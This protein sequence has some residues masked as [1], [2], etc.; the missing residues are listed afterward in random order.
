MLPEI[1]LFGK[2]IGTYTLLAL[3]GGLIA[4][5]YFIKAVVRR[6]QRDYQAVFFLLWVILGVLVGG[7]LLYAIVN[8][9][10]LPMRLKQEGLLGL[11]GLFGGSVFYGGLIGGLVAGLIS[12]KVMKVDF[13]TY[14]ACMAPIIPLFHAI[15]R[16]GCFLGG[17]CY[18]VVSEFGFVVHGNPY[19][20]FINGISRFPVQLLESGLNLILAAVLFYLLKKSDKNEKLKSSM[21]RIYLISYACI[22]I[23]TEFFRGDIY[24]GFIGPLSTSQFISIIILIVC[25]ASYV[26]PKFVK[27][28]KVSVRRSVFKDT[29]QL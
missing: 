23:F 4:A 17:C 7:H 16:V 10:T 13:L 18:G 5:Y 15:A 27:T 24:R 8:I 20:P 9:G 2:P 25:I 6:G 11:V 19:V 1:V 12:I 28:K 26:L 22:R 3:I 29:A 21:L 14:S